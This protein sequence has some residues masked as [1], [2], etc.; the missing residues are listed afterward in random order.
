M[1]ICGPVLVGKP[2]RLVIPLGSCTVP[3]PDASQVRSTNYEGM[4]CMNPLTR[5]TGYFWVKYFDRS[6]GEYFK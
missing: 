1:H 5:L 3:L 6:S 2:I 4:R